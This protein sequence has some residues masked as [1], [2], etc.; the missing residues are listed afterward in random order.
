MNPEVQQLLTDNPDSSE[1]MSLPEDQ[2]RD[3]MHS[4]GV[5]LGLTKGRIA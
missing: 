3:Q 5:I 2:M 4:R 1:G